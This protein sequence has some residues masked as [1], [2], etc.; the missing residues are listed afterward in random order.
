MYDERRYWSSRYSSG[1]TSGAGSEG[2]EADWKRLQI[3]GL[4]DKYSVKSVIDLGCGDG[5]LMFPVLGVYPL[6]EYI[7]VDLADSII[8]KHKATSFIRDGRT[9][10]IRA[11][12]SDGALQSDLVLMI[13]VLFHL[14][15]Q[16]EHDKAIRSFCGSV[17]RVGVLSCWN[18]KIADDVL[19]AHCFY[20][21]TVIPSGFN[22]KR[23]PI[24]GV[25]VKDLLIITPK[26]N[27]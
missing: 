10:F 22:V 9:E 17:K 19:A 6:L 15:S 5:Q 2:Y 7:G 27:P 16:T 14:R 21:E 26:A 24:P 3:I 11:G 8:Q 25:P 4:L 12:I 1:L 20:R 18:N 13:D 23:M